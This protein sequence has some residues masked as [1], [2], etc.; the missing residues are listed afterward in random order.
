MST[1]VKRITR[2]RVTSRLA[3]HVNAHTHSHSHSSHTGASGEST[4]RNDIIFATSPQHEKPNLEMLRKI[5]DHIETG[6][7]AYTDSVV[8][9]LHNRLTDTHPGAVLNALVAT[10]YLVNH[11]PDGSPRSSNFRLELERRLLAP[12]TLLAKGLPADDGLE[13]PPHGVRAAALHAL[14]GWSRTITRPAFA[15]AYRDAT[16]HTPSP[17]APEKGS[18]SSTPKRGPSRNGGARTPQQRLHAEPIAA[19]ADPVLSGMPSAPKDDGAFVTFY[20]K[21]LESF[22]TLH[23]VGKVPL[24][25]QRIKNLRAFMEGNFDRL[26]SLVESSAAS[27]TDDHRKRAVVAQV[28]LER[29]RKFPDFKPPGP[30]PPPYPPPPVSSYPR[31]TGSN[32][33]AADSIPVAQ[34]PASELAPPRAVGTSSAQ[35]RMLIAL[36]ATFATPSAHA[37]IPQPHWTEPHFASL[38]H[39]LVAG[40]GGGDPAGSVQRL[41]SYP[42]PRPQGHHSMPPIQAGGGPGMHYTMQRPQGHH[43]MP[44]I[45]AGGGPAMHY[46]LQRP[47][48]PP[49]HP[50]SYQYPQ[51]PAGGHL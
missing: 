10:E 40:P 5:A 31:R 17:P 41:G 30:A 3:E 28:A 26:R 33:P 16:V 49:M 45:Q 43:S 42:P 20:K 37:R 24:E 9:A 2:G 48:G 14:Q 44:P 22:D 32:V 18:G 38:P 11:L 34:P 50:H 6:Q 7:A 4:R 15:D 47:Q 23:R 8:R 27:R 1:F 19:A 46:P 29:L 12:I 21:R 25:D 13:Y 39:N 36:A 51:Y 35:R